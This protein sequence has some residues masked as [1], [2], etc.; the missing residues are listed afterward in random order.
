MSPATIPDRLPLNPDAWFVGGGVEV[1]LGEEEEETSVVLCMEE[2]EG[3]IVV[4][5]WT[6]IDTLL[7]MK[8]GTGVRVEAAT[9]VLLGV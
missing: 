9:V 4:W 1:L 7:E 3:E 5:V 8:V 6:D 2:T